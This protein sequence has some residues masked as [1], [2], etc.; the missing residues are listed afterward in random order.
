M[1]DILNITRTLQNLRIEGG[2]FFPP[3]YF[4]HLLKHTNL[5]G[6]KKIFMR[7]KYIRKLIDVDLTTNF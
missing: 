7:N 1:S 6:G 4:F 5:H 3:I 2:S